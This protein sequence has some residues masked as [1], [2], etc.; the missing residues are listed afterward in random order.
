MLAHLAAL[1]LSVNL[2][3]HVTHLTTSKFEALVDG[4]DKKT[5]WFVMFHGEHCPSCQVVYPEV[6]RASQDGAGLVQF[7]EVDNRAEYALAQRFGV[8][9]IPTFYIFAHRKELVW[10][11]PVSARAI[12]AAAA[13]H[14][15][16][17]S[18]T[19]NASWLRDPALRAAILFSDSDAAPPVWAGV[20]CAVGDRIAVGKT[21]NAT[22]FRRFRVRKAPAIVLVDG[23]R[24]WTYTGPVAVPDIAGAIKR[25]FAG[26]ITPTPAPT[27]PPRERARPIADA[28][29]FRR[30]C[31]DSG[32]FC[33]LHGADA[34]ATQLEDLAQCYNR[35]R[36]RFFTCGAECPLT[37]ARSGV[38]IFH[39][40]REEAIVVDDLGA[41]AAAL[42]QVL[43]G[44][45]TFTPVKKLKERQT[46]V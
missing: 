1:S 16:D 32:A 17:L 24:Q 35:D 33:V 46:T 25:F 40:R 20:S 28:A 4:R 7:G 10:R 11:E 12:L 45:A 18:R 19:V 14:V 36:F 27:R 44:T 29:T 5:V 22:Y 37:Y 9:T 42:D 3:A 30:E 34:A 26:E 39:S 15:P 31:R 6:V 43:D 13:Q 23:D 38:W 2:G 21:R 8:T 41:V